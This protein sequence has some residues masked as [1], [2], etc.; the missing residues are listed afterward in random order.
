ML[1][2]NVVEIDKTTGMP[3]KRIDAVW[4]LEPSPAEA[5]WGRK[6]PLA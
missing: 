4:L 1:E 6:F 5:I 3:T 2:A